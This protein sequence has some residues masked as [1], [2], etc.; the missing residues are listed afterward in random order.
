MGF[1]GGFGWFCFVVEFILPLAFDLG[2]I[3]SQAS[4][5]AYSQGLSL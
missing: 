1:W 4:K 2:T 3:S 5:S